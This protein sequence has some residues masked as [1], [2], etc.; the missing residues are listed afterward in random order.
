MSL[1]ALLLNRASR[2]RERFALRIGDTRTPYENLTGFSFD[3]T[4]LLR[5]FE[6]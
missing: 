4:L 5:P 1:S 3:V 6:V 2:H